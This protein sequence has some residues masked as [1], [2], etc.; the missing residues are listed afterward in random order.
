MHLYWLINSN[1]P[2]T[3]PVTPHQP[4]AATGADS[5]L[6]ASHFIVDIITLPSLTL[7]TTLPAHLRWSQKV[8]VQLMNLVF[9]PE[10]KALRWFDSEASG[11]EL[12]Q[13]P[14]AP[15]AAAAARL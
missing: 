7:K 14:A 13:S 2:A 5:V 1:E 15:A 9:T 3:L 10:D 4:H 11:V 6:P 8:W 12:C